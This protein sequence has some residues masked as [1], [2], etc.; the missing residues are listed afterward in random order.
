VNPSRDAI[1]L[2]DVN[3]SQQ[4]GKDGANLHASELM[5]QT[6]MG[7]SAKGHVLIGRPVNFEGV[8]V[9]KYSLVSIGRTEE[10]RERLPRSH[11]SSSNLSVTG[12]C[13]HEMMHGRCPAQYFIDR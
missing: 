5:A 9:C 12:C 1:Q 13:A 11:L 10:K 2:N 8:R 7:T 4:F 3:P 6:E